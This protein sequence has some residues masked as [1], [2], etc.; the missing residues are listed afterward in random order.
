MGAAAM[1]FVGD[2]GRQERE[3]LRQQRDKFIKGLVAVGFELAL[4]GSQGTR[5]HPSNVNI[6]F[7]GI[8][9]HDLLGVLQPWVAASTGSACTSGLPEPSHVLRAIGLSE[10]E[11]ESS[12]R[13][14]F[15]R[16][17]SEV[18]LSEVVSLVKNGL[19]RLADAGVVDTNQNSTESLT[20]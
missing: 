2:A 1:T 6:R 12:V 3:F 20:A 7:K 18:E 19:M 15:G 11:A 16:G 13:F 8:S 9:G 5:R 10:Q 4:N 14:S 17:T